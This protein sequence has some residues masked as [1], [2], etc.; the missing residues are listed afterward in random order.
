VAVIIGGGRHHRRAGAT[1]LTEPNPQHPLAAGHARQPLLFEDL[2]GATGEHPHRAL[3]LRLQK[4]ERPAG[5][6]HL[7]LELPKGR[8]IHFGSAEGMGAA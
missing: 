6:C 3:V 5:P 2:V 8:F 4:G 7:D 1:Q